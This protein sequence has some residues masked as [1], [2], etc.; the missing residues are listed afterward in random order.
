MRA[1][2]EPDPEYWES[3]SN[4]SVEI[5]QGGRLL[6]LWKIKFRR[7]PWHIEFSDFDDYA[8]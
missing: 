5:F 4:I 6:P 8:E 7:L 1:W 3:D 2:V